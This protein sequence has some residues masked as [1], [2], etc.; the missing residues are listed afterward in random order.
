MLILDTTFIIDALRGNKEV[1]SKLSE[2]ELE[3]E[4]I[5][6]TSLNVLELFKGAYRSNKKDENINGMQRLIEQ[7]LVLPI[8]EDVYDIYGAISS[9]QFLRGEPIGDFDEVIAAIALSY[10]AMIITKDRHFGRIPMLKVI[11][12]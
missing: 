6:T 7:L 4:A 11:Y 8:A 10:D 1:L 3:N 9:E 5:C 12:Y 2:L